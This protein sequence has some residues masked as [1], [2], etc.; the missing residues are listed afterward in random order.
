MLGRTRLVHERVRA[1]VP[2]V[3]TDR[4]MA[5]DVATVLAMLQNG[6]LTKDLVDQ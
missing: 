1:E 6:S 2:F 3:A 4:P 5:D